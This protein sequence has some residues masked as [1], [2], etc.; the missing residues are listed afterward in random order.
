MID[1]II[2]DDDG[3]ILRTGKC[4]ESI[5]Y[6]QINEG[7]HIMQGVASD[8]K[9]II[10]DGEIADK[11]VDNSVD[12]IKVRQ[13]RNRMLSQTDW[14]QMPDSPLSDTEKERYK[15]YRQEL[16]DLPSKYDTI[17]SIEEL[18]FPNIEDF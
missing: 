12:M 17:N 5:L 3:N 14:T 2:Y 7:E 15:R 8:D 1:F 9:H 16:R 4:P 6:T 11:P 13:E 10:I 18:T